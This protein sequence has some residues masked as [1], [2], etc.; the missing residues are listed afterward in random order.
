MANGNYEWEGCMEKIITT[1]TYQFTENRNRQAATEMAQKSKLQKDGM[2][3][4]KVMGSHVGEKQNR[5]RATEVRTSSMCY[6]YP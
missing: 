1:R 5:K 4:E 2:I 6:M 3:R